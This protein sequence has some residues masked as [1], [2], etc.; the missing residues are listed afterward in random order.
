MI[1]ILFSRMLASKIPMALDEETCD[2]AMLVTSRSREVVYVCVSM[3][4][5]VAMA[6]QII[7][8]VC[9]ICDFMIQV[10]GWKAIGRLAISYSKFLR[11]SRRRMWAHSCANAASRSGAGQLWKNP[12]GTRSAGRNTPSVTG[13]ATSQDSKIRASLTEN[14]CRHRFQAECVSASSNSV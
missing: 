8:R 9:A 13:P 3:T 6:S 14:S 12:R 11:K 5:C 2:A 10:T 4:V 1:M 7:S